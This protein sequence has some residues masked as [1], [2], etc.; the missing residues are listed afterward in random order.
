MEARD[1]ARDAAARDLP[2]QGGQGVEHERV[3]VLEPARM[4]GTPG[5]VGSELVAHAVTGDRLLDARE[6]D[7]AR[8]RRR[9]RGD[10]EPVAAAGVEPEDGRGGPPAQTIRQEATT[11][12]GG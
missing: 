6:E 8:I 11:P 5:V 10:E 4:E 1:R 2:G 9:G 3:R 7:E 12:S